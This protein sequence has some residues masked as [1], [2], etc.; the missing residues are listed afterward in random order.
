MFCLTVHLTTYCQTIEF[1]NVGWQDGP[2]N[3]IYIERSDVEDFEII[4]YCQT[5]GFFN[6]GWQ[7]RPMNNLYIERNDVVNI[8]IID[9]Y[10]YPII[11]VKV[12]DGIYDVIKT[13]VTNNSNCKVPSRGEY[14]TNPQEGS[15]GNYDWG[16]YAV[17]IQSDF[18]FYF[19][20]GGK[21]SKK[22]FHGLINTLKKSGY[23][24]VAII[25]DKEI[26][27]EF[28]YLGEDSQEDLPSETETPK[29]YYWLVCTI[30]AILFIVVL[31]IK[32]FIKR[33]KVHSS[34]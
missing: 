11:R 29:T 18:I 33:L 21:E 5:I 6:V 14:H 25:F 31:V 34:D 9:L 22:Y 32:M 2:V 30:V 24:N 10:P 15:V 17:T 27:P 19:M 12:N 1:F 4:D 13:Y 3:N 26:M 28:W 23:S 8:E 16:S 20:E 7:D